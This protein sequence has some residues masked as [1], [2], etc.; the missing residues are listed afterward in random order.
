MGKN[1]ILVKVKNLTGKVISDI[2]F[3]HRYD[4]DVYNNGHLD[5]LGV[6]DI[7]NIGQAD[8]WTGLF[9]HGVDYWWIKFKIDGVYKTCK[10]NFYCYLTS[11]DADY[12]K[13]H[14]NGYVLL[15]LEE[16]K[17]TVIPPKSSSA[18]VSLYKESLLFEKLTNRFEAIENE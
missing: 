4:S 6:N 11:E 9:R 3:L 18:S 2:T 13:K 7:D 14:P 5:T 1:T 8:F 17:M 12:I 15:K 16:N 10:A